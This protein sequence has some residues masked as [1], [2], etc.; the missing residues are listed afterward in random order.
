[1]QRSA[2]PTQN[3][4]APLKRL[5]KETAHPIC[6]SESQ[7]C[8]R[9]NGLNSTSPL[10]VNSN[11]KHRGVAGRRGHYSNEK[12]CGAS[13]ANSGCSGTKAQPGSAS[14]ESW[15]RA[16]IQEADPWH[17]GFSREEGGAKLQL[18]CCRPT[19]WPSPHFFWLLT[20]KPID[21]E[22]PS[23]HGEVQGEGIQTAQAFSIYRRAVTRC[24]MSNMEKSNMGAIKRSCN[25]K[26]GCM[27]HTIR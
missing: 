22:K 19:L 24:R 7:L 18:P 9:K 16:G 15:A 26:Y 12:V 3:Q 5:S 14:V 25:I 4:E 23:P 27:P 21:T 2:T 20:A 10:Q 11:L 13:G 1:M 8:S 6:V 17:R